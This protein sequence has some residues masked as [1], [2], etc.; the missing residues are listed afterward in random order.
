M[1]ESWGLQQ[2]KFYFLCLCYD[3]NT[4]L[5]ERPLLSDYGEITIY[6]DTR[7]CYHK[8]HI[9]TREIVSIIKNPI[10]DYIFW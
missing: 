9:K 7:A 3:T 2:E 6:Q 8:L 1:S 4:S 5:K 10:Y